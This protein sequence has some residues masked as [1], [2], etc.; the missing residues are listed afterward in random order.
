[1]INFAN[2]TTPTVL[3]DEKRESAFISGGKR[4][5]RFGKMEGKLA[6]SLEDGKR[7]F[8]II[9]TYLKVHKGETVSTRISSGVPLF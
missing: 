8:R 6:A 5:F 7:G 4:F 9:R 2:K 1:M 3:L